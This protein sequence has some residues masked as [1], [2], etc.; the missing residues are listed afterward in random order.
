MHY[1]PL[2]EKGILVKLGGQRSS[3]GR[4][5]SASILVCMIILIF[6]RIVLFHGG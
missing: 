4:Y 3:A 1:I 5:N 6:G 2:G